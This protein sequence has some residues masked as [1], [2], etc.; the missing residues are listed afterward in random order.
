MKFVNK[1]AIIA[2]FVV[3]IG[4]T[5]VLNANAKILT[6]TIYSQL[7]D[8]PIVDGYLNDPEWSNAITESYTMYS[9]TNQSDTMALEVKSIYSDFNSISYGFTVYDDNFIGAEVFVIFIK[10]NESADLVQFNGLNPYL[11]NGN[12]AKGIFLGS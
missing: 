1:I 10:V 4:F 11:E 6:G 8:K 7:S 2:F 12:D 9:H 5:P 3:L